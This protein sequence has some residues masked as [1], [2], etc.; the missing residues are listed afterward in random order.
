MRCA[1]PVPV[2]HNP[3]NVRITQEVQRAF[4]VLLRSLSVFDDHDDPV[5]SLGEH[6]SV[7]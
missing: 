6:R 5:A 2:D 4:Q 7:H 1:T 3:E